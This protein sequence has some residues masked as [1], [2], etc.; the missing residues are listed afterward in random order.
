MATDDARRGTLEETNGRTGQGPSQ[1]THPAGSSTQGS[2][3]HGGSPTTQSA[4]DT[5]Q[6][7]SS[8]G[9]RMDGQD[10]GIDTGGFADKAQSA[11][12]Q[13]TD[14]L[15]SK[16]GPA[17]S[18]ASDKAQAVAGQAA[19]R[20]QEVLEQAPEN[21][22]EAS[23]NMFERLQRMSSRDYYYA[24]SVSLGLSTLFLLFG[25]RSL[26]SFVGLWSGIVL[27]LGLLSRFEREAEQRSGR[28][29]R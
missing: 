13:V 8:T 12:G 29:M 22:Y 10:R 26:A 27:N 16:V 9:N 4:P 5:T 15:G 19:D 3:F 6:K 24:A 11:V 2:S 20:M 7:G 18:Q 25:R 1:D 17:V 14:Q 28:S 21:V 23:N